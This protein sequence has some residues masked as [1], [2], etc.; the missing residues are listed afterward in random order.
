MLYSPAFS[1]TSGNQYS[2]IIL[3]MKLAAR[4]LALGLNGRSDAVVMDYLRTEET[5]Q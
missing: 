5:P 1:L 2:F 4:I 3:N